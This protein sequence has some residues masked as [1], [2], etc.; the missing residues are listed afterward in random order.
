MMS[1]TRASIEG[2]HPARLVVLTVLFSLASLVQCARA[3]ELSDGSHVRT[4][5]PR[6]RAA[7]VDGVERSALFRD[8]VE[9]LDGSDVIVYAEIDC[10]MPTRLQGSLTFM[11]TAGAR[12]YVMVKIASSVTGQAQT[13]ILGHELQHALEVAN[14][15]SVVDE[16]S[17]A[18]EYRRIGFASGAL[19][20]GAGFDSRAAIEVGYRVWMELSHRGE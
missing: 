10:L 9:Q 1:F 3:G 19:Q 6:I 14:A 13:A 12:R 17:L 4:S 7:I 2:M 11:S 5:D 18:D 15:S 20:R 16:Q 8:L